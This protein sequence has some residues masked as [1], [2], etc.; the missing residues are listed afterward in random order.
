MILSTE[1]RVAHLCGGQDGD[2]AAG[3]LANL[4]EE[5]ERVKELV[6]MRGTDEEDGALLGN[7]ESTARPV[8]YVSKLFMPIKIIADM[9][10]ASVPVRG[11]QQ[12]EEL[13]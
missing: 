2:T 10:R 8:P 11:K 13:T 7:I 1:A 9:G 6:G 4:G 5:Q 3:L 12:R